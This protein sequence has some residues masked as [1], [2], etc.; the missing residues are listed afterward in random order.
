MKNFTENDKT[1]ISAVIGFSLL[2]IGLVIICYAVANYERKFVLRNMPDKPYRPEKP[3]IIMYKAPEELLNRR[4]KRLFHYKCYDKN[5][6]TLDFYD[7]SD[8]YNMGDTI[9]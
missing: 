6:K 2:I 5:G 4:E 9:K 1:F 8:K 7:T 3:F